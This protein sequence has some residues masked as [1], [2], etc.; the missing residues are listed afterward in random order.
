MS[1]LPGDMSGKPLIVGNTYRL[2]GYPTQRQLMRM[3]YYQ[4]QRWEQMYM[5]SQ[6]VSNHAV[7]STDHQGTM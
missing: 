4:R 7:T 6:H 2:D 3:P 1:L 5:V